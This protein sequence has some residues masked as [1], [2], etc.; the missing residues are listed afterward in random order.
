VHFLY[1]LST[2]DCCPLITFLP[3]RLACDFQWLKLAYE[4][5]FLPIVKSYEHVKASG[6]HFLLRTD[7]SRLQEP[8]VSLVVLTSATNT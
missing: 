7:M 3:Y 5:C 2:I 4:S 8:A 1:P 6:L